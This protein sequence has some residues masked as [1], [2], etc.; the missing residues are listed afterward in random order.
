MQ[1][2]NER[3]ED[4]AGHGLRDKLIIQGIIC[5][6]ML[7]AVMVLCLID[8]PRAAAVRVSLSSAVAGNVTAGQVT[9][10][11]RKRFFNREPDEINLEAPPAEVIAAPVLHTVPRIDEDVLHELHSRTA[12]DDELKK[13]SAPEPTAMPEH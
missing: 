10:E 11:I 7:A 1:E 9:E 3:Q 2:E 13:S 4:R 5:A 12:D 8:H 6:V